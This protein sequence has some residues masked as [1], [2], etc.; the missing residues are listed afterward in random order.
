MSRAFVRDDDGGEGSE[1]LPDRL[2]SSHRNLVTESGLA[3]IEAEL[4]ALG[5]AYAQAQGAADRIGLQ[6][7]AREMRYWTARRAS[8]E[9]QSAPPKDGIVHFGSRVTIL[10]EDGRRA[11]YRIVGEDEA[12]PAKGSLSY[13]SP[14]AQALM[15]RR[16]GDEVTAGQGTAE[17]EAI[18]Q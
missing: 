7:I 11:S 8:A 14:L 4:E 15:G 18:G 13:V 1:D 12:N 16:V 17:I 10:R 6:K 9:V 2:I 5:V 3:M